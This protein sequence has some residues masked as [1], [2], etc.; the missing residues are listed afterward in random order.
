MTVNDFEKAIDRFG[1]NVVIDEMVLRK[2][3]VR[4]VYAHS[5]AAYYKWDGSGRGYFC[6]SE[7]ELPESVIE[8]RC[9][10]YECDWKRDMNYNLIFE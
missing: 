5:P 9:T 2:N 6:P 8:T 10:V 3:K 4:V 1:R 7:E